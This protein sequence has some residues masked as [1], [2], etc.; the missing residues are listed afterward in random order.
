MKR[1]LTS[2]L[3]IVALATS[4]TSQATI[5]PLPALSMMAGLENWRHLDGR[6]AEWHRLDDGAIEVAPGTGNIITKVLFGDSLVELDF[7]CPVMPDAMGQA[8]GNSGVYLQGLYEVQ[9]LDSFGFEAGLNTC[10]AIYNVAV[11]LT[12]ASLP[13]GEWQHYAIE[14]TAPRFDKEGNVTENARITAHLNGTLIQDDI[15]VPAPTGSASGRDAVEYGPLMLQDHGNLVRYRN[16]AI[17][18]RFPDDEPD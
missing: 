12:N 4:C 5:A 1:T 7:M 16:V 8:R 18:P 17:T 2:L 13:P 14:F 9:V 6:P 15:E 11:P 10:G 3:A